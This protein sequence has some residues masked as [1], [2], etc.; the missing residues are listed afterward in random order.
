MDIDL[1]SA[2]AGTTF[3]PVITTDPRVARRAD[4][5][6]IDAWGYIYGESGE[7]TYFNTLQLRSFEGAELVTGLWGA[8]QQAYNLRLKI[9]GTGVRQPEAAHEYPLACPS[10][11]FNLRD[12]FGIPLPED[13]YDGAV[14][15]QIKR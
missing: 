2:V 14:Y 9:A 7:F 4:G 8:D 10:W 1:G 12:D 6:I 5:E 11:P 15:R 3:L 13:V